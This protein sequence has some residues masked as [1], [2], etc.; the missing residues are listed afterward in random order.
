MD[1]DVFRE[2]LGHRARDVAPGQAALR[3]EALLNFHAG[4]PTAAAD[5]TVLA[6]ALAPAL[7]E[8]AQ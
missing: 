2:E 1:V 6:P 3:H 8:V 4:L 5:I 7:L